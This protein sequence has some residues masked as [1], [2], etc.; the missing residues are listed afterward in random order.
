MLPPQEA[1]RREHW[2]ALIGALA[3]TTAAIAMVCGQDLDLPVEKPGPKRQPPKPPDDPPPVTQEDEKPPTIYG[4]EVKSE[5]ASI[6]YV[7]DVSGSMGLDNQFAANGDFLDRLGRA[8]VELS[9]SVAS[10]PKNYRFDVVAFS[11]GNEWWS[12]TLQGADDAHKAAAQAWIGDLRPL[13]GTWVCDAM[14][15]ALWLRENKLVILLTDGEPTCGW[16]QDH[17]AV[18]RAANTQG[19][20]VDVFGISCTP[21]S[22]MDTF[23][24]G[25]AQDNNGNYTPVR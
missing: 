13:S 19:A 7:I 20:R 25:V 3:V 16:H 21:G 22:L 24:R 1:V 12:P 6:V 5:S 10:L 23:C 9:K 14:C 4:S 11:C 17:R 18:I 15:A 8:K 2:L